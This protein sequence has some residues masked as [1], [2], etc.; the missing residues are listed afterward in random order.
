MKAVS[1]R[2]AVLFSIAAIAACGS[3][4]PGD[5]TELSP[6]SGQ[7]PALEL[8]TMPH[9]ELTEVQSTDGVTIRFDQRGQGDINVVLVHGW[10]CDSGYWQHQRN[11]LAERYR[12][13]S[14]DLAGHGKSGSNRNDWSM[15]AFGEDVVAVITALDLDNIVLVGH[16]MGGPV[17]L[18]AAR[19]LKDRVIG[20]VGADTLWSVGQPVS[21]DRRQAYINKMQDNFT[22]EVIAIVENMFLADANPSVRDFVIRDMAS[23]PPEVGIP[24]LIALNDYDDEGGLERLAVP[25]VLINSDYRPNNLAPLQQRVRDFQFIEMTGVGHF[26]MLEDPA[27]FNAHLETAIQG[28]AAK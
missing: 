17:V 19:Q 10:G 12:V 5:E 13:I 8:M 6:G 1:L 20:V 27:T 24:S 3:E 22:A 11:W 26:V 4:Q 16:S 25:M 14:V 9:N 21:P 18:E 28:F 7:S 23:T 2:F 15:T